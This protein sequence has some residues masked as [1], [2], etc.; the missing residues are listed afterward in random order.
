MSVCLGCG[1]VCD[2]VAVEVRDGRIVRVAPVCERG[3]RWFGDGVVPAGARI[4]G[5]D[6]GVEAAITDA[7]ALLAAARGRVLV[8][9]A[10]DLTTEAHRELVALGDLLGAA[11]DGVTSSAAAQGILAGQRRGRASAT[12][13][14]VRHRADLVL[15]WGVDPA[16]RYS[17]FEERFVNAPGQQVPQGRAGRTIV[18]VSVGDDRGPADA[19]LALTIASKDEVTALSLLRAAARGVPMG[20]LPARLAGLADLAARLLRARYVA[21]VHDAEQAGDRDPARA[22]ALVTLTQAL[23][24]PTRAALVSLRDGGNRTGFESLL[25]WQTGY[26]MAVDFADGAPV[27]TPGKRG[28]SR[29]GSFDLVLVGGDLDALGSPVWRDEIVARPLIVVG[30]RATVH[31]PGAAVAIDT[32]VAAIHEAGTGYRMDDVPLPLEPVLTHPHSA[33]ATFAA[34]RTTVRP[35]L[36]GAP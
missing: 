10:P 2:D 22:E 6:A 4:R 15:Y 14:E 19:G 25:T 33:R 1:C 5:A 31:A 26:P 9:A 8:V 3:A 21:V 36:V 11:V 20:E 12:L 13:G 18:S 7:A 17:R 27:Y 34:L 24:G 35:R 16:R 29:P 28:L 30:P 32:G 23:N